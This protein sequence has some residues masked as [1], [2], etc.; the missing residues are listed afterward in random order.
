[1]NT[2]KLF[3]NTALLLLAGLLSAA[4][5]ADEE[6]DN[7]PQEPPVREL[8][9]ARMV[10]EGGR[11]DFD[12]AAG[13]A[14]RATTATWQDGDKV[15]MQFTAG[16]ER[17]DGVAV[18]QAASDEWNVQYYGAIPSGTE[19]AC[20]AYFF[21]SPAAVTATQVTLG[22]TSAVYAD[23]AA[24]YRLEQGEM[25]VT[26]RLTP[27]TGRFRF[28]G[29]AG[30]AFTAY[31]FKNYTQYS[32]AD[33]GLTAA[34]CTVS[35]TIGSDGYSPY[36]YG[37]FA[38]GAE[39]D[40]YV[41]DWTNMLLFTKTLSENALALGRSGYLN[42]PTLESRS[43]WTMEEI[44]EKHLTVKGVEFT[45]KPVKGGTFTMG[46]TAE[47]TGAE[48]DESPTHRVT[49]SNYWIGETEVTQALWKAVTGYSPTS[50]GSSWSSSYGLGDNYPAYYISYEDVQSFITQLNSLTGC[51][52][53]M[54]TEAEWE[55]AARGGSQSKGYLYSGGNAIGDVAWYTGNSSSKTHPVAQK[56]P[57]ELG[58][59]DMSGN[60]WEWCSDWYGSYSASDQTNP[61]GPASGSVRVLRGGC[62]GSNATIC[63][64][65]YRS[66]RTP[67]DRSN[68]VGVRL[69]SSSFPK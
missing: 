37:Y 60:V 10:L 51:T 58:L 34:D 41:E 25:R 65:A 8:H 9:T 40:L 35:G 66:I 11:A 13:P 7:Q 69:A 28:K 54:L 19:A 63:R 27:Q 5:S 68:L 32:I 21:E 2:F 24:T 16:T 64:V 22:S 56:A 36:Y 57:N 50:G 31:G 15:F 33:N 49:L 59:Y 39:K 44:T 52:F 14:S 26:A 43:G 67:S 17:V 3:S 18:Y 23:K 45:M 47:Q 29:E 62:W 46:A 55:Y 53:R 48:N 6:L 12:D 38:E 4:C 61:T 1:M 20:E 42:L 30:A